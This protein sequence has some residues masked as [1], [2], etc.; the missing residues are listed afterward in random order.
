M[1]DAVLDGAVL[2]LENLRCI[3]D[4]ADEQILPHEVRHH[5]KNSNSIQFRRKNNCDSECDAMLRD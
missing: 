2:V 3:A 4:V 1:S 5:R